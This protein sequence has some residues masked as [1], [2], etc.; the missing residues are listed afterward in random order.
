MHDSAT[1]VFVLSVVLLFYFL[2]GYPLLLAVFPGVT[3]RRSPR[4]RRGSGQ[5][6]FSPVYNGASFLRQKLESIVALDY[7]RE[8]LDVLVISD[9]STDATDSIAGE[10]VSSGVRLLRVPKGGKAAALNAGIGQARGEILFFTDVRQRLAPDSLRH[11]VASLA[12]PSVGSV[13]GEL[14][15]VT[16]DRQEE[17]DMGL[18]WRYEVWAPRK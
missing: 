1:I 6:R 17:A 2:F 14:H 11:L 10:F 5:S 9:G 3:G 13:T 16:G 8:L 12:D 18:Y 7:P 15:I 4:I